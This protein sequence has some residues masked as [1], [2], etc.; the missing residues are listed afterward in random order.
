M[1]EQKTLML[2]PALIGGVIAGFLSGV[3]VLSCL[4]CLWII[5]G[6]MLAAYLLVKDSSAPLTSSDGAIVGV[7]TGLVA[8]VVQTVVSLLFLPLNR[9]VMQRIMERLAE[10]MEEMPPGFENLLD[11]TSMET[12]VPRILFGL[13]VSGV[14]FSVL[15]ALGGIIGLSLFKKK[16]PQPPQGDLHVPESPGDRQP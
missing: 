11:E 2:T 1:N 9:Q 6:A 8:A 3:P 13:V 10:Y 14:I 4:C 12:S 5:G 7:F 16:P 15:G